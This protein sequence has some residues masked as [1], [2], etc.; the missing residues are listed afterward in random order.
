MAGKENK[1]KKPAGKFSK[2]RSAFLKATLGSALLFGTYHVAAPDP[3]KD[4]VAATLTAV[5]GARAAYADRAMDLDFTLLDQ[6]PAILG[7]TGNAI[8][9]TQDNHMTEWYA[10]VGRHQMLMAQPANRAAF[11][12]FLQPLDS[13]RNASVADKAKAVDAL[14]DRMITYQLD[15]DHY[16]SQRT[17]YWASPLETIRDRRGDCEDFA[18]LKY[19]ALRHLDVEAA[20]LF[21]ITVGP[22]NED[23][24]NHA[25][26]AVD[27][28]D[29]ANDETDKPPVRNFVILDND[30]SRN[31]L[32]VPENTDRYKLYAA[33]SEV[34]IWSVPQPP[35][36]PAP[37]PEATPTPPQ[38]PCTCA[39]PP[40]S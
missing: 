22:A 32:L 29:A 12:E 9:E 24:L 3:V 34:G 38:G 31:G 37:K 7:S 23:K 26:L 40:A 39:V 21:V 30:S 27:I 11:E 5:F 8:F 36:P 2:F 4:Q 33:Y 6:S 16:N 25:V 18:I 13:L 19:F 17:E 15:G 10:V 1:Q 20:R 28:R 14:I 35:K